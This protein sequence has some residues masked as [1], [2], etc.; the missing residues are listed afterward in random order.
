[1]DLSRQEYPALLQSLQPHQAVA[2]LDERVKLIGKVNLD[3]AEWLSERRRVEEAY[4]QGLRKLGSRRPNTAPSEFGSIF[5]TSWQNIISSTESLAASHSQ[6]A[7]SIEADVERPLRSYQRE[8]REM[9]A[10]STIQ[11][12]LGAVAKELDAAQKRA[13]RM[14]AGKSSASKVAEAISSAEAID[15]EWQNQAPYVFEQLQALDENRV[16]HLRDVLTQLETHEVDQVERSRVSAESCLNTLLNVDT[17]EEI[18]AFVARTSAGLPTIQPSTRSRT[19]SGNVLSTPTPSRAQDDRASEISATSEGAPRSSSAAGPPPT[20]ETK[21]QRFGLRRLGTV[22]GRRKD[23]K[24]AADRPPSPEKRSRPHLNP[25]RRG[26]SSKNM[27]TIPSPDEEAMPMP[28]SPP[29]RSTTSPQPTRSQTVAVSPTPEQR[30]TNERVNG[31]VT[32][33]AP[34]RSST[35]P[36]ANEVQT[37]AALVEEEPGQVA[38]AQTS[39]TQRDNE[40]FNIAPPARDEISR[41]QQEAASNDSDQPQFRLDIRSEPIREE[42][43][44]AQS[45]LSSVASTLR[46]QAQQIPTPRKPTTNRGRRDVRNTVFVP[47]PQPSD[48]PGPS[49]S[50]I[51]PPSIFGNAS[52]LSSEPPQ[53][54]DA[55]SIRSAHS[56]SSIVPNAAKHAEMTKPGLNASVVETVSASFTSGQVTK[57]VVIGEL[58]LAH[59]ASEGTPN[60][61]TENIRLENFP[62]LEKVAP[63]PSF[64]TQTP[65]K[66]GEYSVNLSQLS[67]TAVAFKYQVHLEDS[68]L[69]AHAPVIITP[70]WKIEPK[71]TSVIV[72]YGFNPAFVSPAGRSVTMKNVVVVVN[73]DST[74]AQ[75]C[76]SKPVGNFSKEKSLIYWKLGD[77][78][79]DGYAEAPQKLL[80]RFSTESEGKPGS[81]EARWEISGEAA[82]GLG[83]GLGLSRSGTPKEEGSPPDPFADEGGAGS[84][85]G[86]WKEVN[87]QRKLVSGAYK[88]N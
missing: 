61:T 4:V 65:S 3:I 66:S 84:P 87:V 38:P 23:S 88:A 14:S 2:V 17:K 28:K 60:A 79:L 6:L 33:P 34:T 13:E 76:Q 37:N 36:V 53:G 78:T 12:N 70:S 25:L 10:M 52:S 20:P 64:I 63:N 81:V 11:G 32:Q 41:A 82:A 29:Q 72:S 74:K 85:T 69:A 51:P 16:N 75:A 39:E 43:L 56:M 47:S 45:A 15:R 48:L 8:N 57:A 58:A 83:S 80:A 7:Q 86:A 50:P 49:D 55:H 27:Q 19:A 71:Q 54:S 62:V 9:Q 40:G 68:N 67:R 77:V 26:T 5:Q 31:E 18:S 46:A 1:M 42:G 35:L 44:D 21:P 24:K 22:M 59:V 30:R 73:L